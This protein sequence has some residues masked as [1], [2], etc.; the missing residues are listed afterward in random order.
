MTKLVKA[1]LCEISGD[2][3]GSEI[4]QPVDVQFNPATLRIAIANRTAGGNQ[5]G[6][7]A[8][9]KP[10]TGEVTVSFDLYFDTAD[11][12]ETDKPIPVTK[13][14]QT[15]EKFVRPRDATPAGQ[16]PPRVQFRWGSVLVQGV[17]ESA[18]IDL[19]LFAADGTPLR[20]KVAV[21]IKGQDPA[22]RYDPLVPPAANGG[23]PGGAQAGLPPG[24]PGTSGG[25]SPAAVAEALPG[26]SLAQLA[27]RAGLDPT[28]WR[29]LANGVTDPQSLPA[30]QEVALPASLRA[31][32]GAPSSAA[33]ASN[34]VIAGQALARAG[35]VTGSATT[36]KRS[37]HAAAAASSAADFGLAPQPGADAAGRSYGNGVPLR[38][39]VGGSGSAPITADPTRPGW[40]ALQ[41][42]P[43]TL[44]PARRRAGCG[45]GD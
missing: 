4:G 31:G 15:V 13:R 23:G 6:S 11:E 3:K 8:K 42:R 5:P 33:S 12:G 27:A 14:T 29:A 28:A 24:T 22:Y 19:E 41:P 30:G 20:A 44:S 34:P 18:N 40:Q 35:G 7:Q 39:L 32:G 9:Q 25:G 17:M 45:C 21:Q 1:Q 36:A 26:E 37:A 2:A 16:S 38:P 10:G 43:V